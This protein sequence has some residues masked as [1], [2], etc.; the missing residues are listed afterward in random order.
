[1]NRSE[2]IEAMHEEI[3]VW[4]L[5][6]P[7]T[8]VL[9]QFLLFY[10]AEYPEHPHWNVVYP[11]NEKC[12]NPKNQNTLE[13]KSHY[14]DLSLVGHIYS[15]TPSSTDV[16]TD[17]YF[18][19]NP[20]KM[21]KSPMD[22]KYYAW[23]EVK[24]LELFSRLVFECFDLN[25]QRIEEFERK[26]RRLD[27]TIPSYFY[28]LYNGSHACGVL[29]LFKS[30]DN[31]LFLMNFGLLKEYRGKGLSWSFSELL[32]H[33]PDYT[34]YTHSNNKI[35]IEKVLPRLNFASLGRLYVQK[36]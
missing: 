9:D 34:I 6:Y 12:L 25:L 36:L 14:A 19:Y 28:V 21:A 10:Y 5:C 11:L 18:R 27:S 15:D 20:A 13:L 7:H 22:L 24:D 23:R 29:S 16:S 33:F 8:I 35:L 4:K 2:I 31:K 30:S 1:M 32:N 26:M 3:L 17:E